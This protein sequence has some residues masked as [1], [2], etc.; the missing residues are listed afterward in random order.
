MVIH[1][2]LLKN[3]Q[4][5]QLHWFRWEGERNSKPKKI[6]FTQKFSW[7]W[8]LTS[9]NISQNGQKFYVDTGKHGVE[10]SVLSQSK[11]RVLKK[12]SGLRLISPQLIC[13]GYAADR[14]RCSH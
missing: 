10:R 9:K 13:P 4:S 12:F 3:C 6:L 2:K 11:G 14:L 5:F 1:R 7:G 8:M